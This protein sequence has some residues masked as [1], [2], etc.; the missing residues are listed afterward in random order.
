MNQFDAAIV[1]A[2]PGGSVAAQRLAAAGINV[3][4]LEKDTFPRNKSC[5][6]GVTSEGLEV[7]K[8]CGLGDWVAGFPVMPALRLSSPGGLILDIPFERYGEGVV[9][10]LIPRRLMDALLAQKAVEAGAELCQNCLVR[11]VRI[12]PAQGV[13]LQTDDGEVN[14]R[15]LILAEGSAGILSRRLGLTREGPELSAVRQYLTGDSGPDDRLEIHFQAGILP[16]YNWI[17]PMGGSRVNIGSGTYTCRVRRGELNLQRELQRFMEDSIT[18]GRLL[19]CEPASAIRGH[20][21]RTQLIDQRTHGDRLLAVGDAAGLVG[22]FSGVGIAP[23][24]RSG[25]MAAEHALR[26]LQHNHFSDKDLAGYSRE[27]R[28]HYGADA[29]AARMLR[30]LLNNPHRLD[31]LFRRLQNDDELALLM[32][33]ILLHK[34]SPRLAFRFSTILRLL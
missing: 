19:H 17:F 2:G 21:L 18:E 33:H 27:L 8:R 29:R 11:D 13:A 22:P 28:D 23:A 25:E 20:P 1:G 26:A 16:G 3:V 6:D 14:A 4:L 9:G 12:D 5:G 30:S 32:G 7:L 15:L 31:A 24:L 34:R 10:R